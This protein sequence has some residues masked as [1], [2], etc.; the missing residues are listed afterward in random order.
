MDPRSQERGQGDPTQLGTSQEDTDKTQEKDKKKRTC[1]FSAEEHEI[2]VRE[3]MEHQ[4]F[5]T[6]KLAIEWKE[7]I[8]QQIVDKINSVAEVRRTVTECK[9]RWHDCKC[10]TKERMSRNR[11]AALQTGGGVQHRKRTWTRWR[12]SLQPSSRGNRHWYHRTAQTTRKQHICR[13]S[14]TGDRNA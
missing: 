10:R 6:S 13:V 11:K 3:V 5:I 2:L 14:C 7:E 9:K 12:R 4:L 1:R 8:W